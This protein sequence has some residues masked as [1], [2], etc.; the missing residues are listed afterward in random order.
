MRHFES[1]TSQCSQLVKMPVRLGVVVFLCWF[2]GCGSSSKQTTTTTTTAAP[3]SYFSPYVQGSV[4]SQAPQTYTLDDVADSF[5]ETSYQ[6]QALP[7]PQVLNAGS[8]G[9]GQRGLR[10]L[11]ITTTYIFDGIH[12]YDPSAVNQPGGYALELAGQAGGLMQMVGQPAAPLVAATTCP[13]SSSAQTYLFI[14]IPNE[15]ASGSAGS[16]PATTWNPATDTAYGS[17]EVTASGGTV[18]FQK[19]QQHT[20][21]SAG[22]SGSP[23]EPS[24][25]SVTGAC[26]P[27]VLGNVTEVPGQLAITDP[28]AG[29]SLP[30]QAQIAI[31][32]TGLL[33]ENNGSG[34]VMTG[35]S[36]VLDY[37]NVLGAGSGAVGLPQPSSALETSAVVG[38]QYLGF[39]YA[40]PGQNSSGGAVPLSSNLVSFGFSST[41]SGCASIAP[42]SSTLI[43]GGDFAGG[44]PASSSSG[45]G[46]CDFALDLGTQDASSNGLY[47]NATVWAGAS[48]AGNTTGATYSFPAVA[49]AGQLG[50]KYAIFLIGFDSAQP[51]AIYLLQSN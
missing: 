21:P 16:E 23:A 18:S 45:F 24:A 29:T 35:S 12:S 22:G 31:G 17:V 19:I 40:A 51:W 13:D 3:Q 37:E 39:I 5:S 46:N 38:A 41:P 49:V 33:A 50:G 2:A 20:L 11:T 30:A 1:Q 9:V 4:G 28:G 32:P 25:A 44:D 14:T 10:N 8:L 47:P 36:P 43:Y 27:S 7:G 6:T 15:Y 48:Y 34:Q 42:G 26:G